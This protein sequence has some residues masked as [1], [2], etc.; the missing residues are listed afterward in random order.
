MSL[1]VGK[2]SFGVFIAA[3][4]CSF[5]LYWSSLKRPDLR[6]GFLLVAH[7][8]SLLTNDPQTTPPVVVFVPEFRW[9]GGGVHGATE[10]EENV[11][12]DKFH[13]MF[14]SEFAY[15]LELSRP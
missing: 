14:L 3:V 6:Q 15:Q 8:E 12:L 11:K 1:R 9:S 13:G 7:N 4:V 2:F 10:G 5:L